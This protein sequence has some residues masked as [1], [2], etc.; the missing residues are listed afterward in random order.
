MPRTTLTMTGTPQPGQP[1][2]EYRGMETSEATTKPTSSPA[3]PE[4]NA[5]PGRES[6]YSALMR[7]GLRIR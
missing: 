5:E 2:N 3:V 4:I 6:I 1:D 7:Q